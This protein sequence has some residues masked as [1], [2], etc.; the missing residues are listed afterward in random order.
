MASA[1]AALR[2]LNPHVLVAPYN[3]FVSEVNAE[4]LVSEY[5]III[6]GTDNYDARVLMAASCVRFSRPYIYGSVYQFEGQVGVFTNSGPG[7]PCYGCYQPLRPSS[8]V[9]PDCA[10]AGVLGVLPGVIGSTQA[11]EAIKLVLGIRSGL[12]NR[13]AH[14]D[15]TE[16]NLHRF[17]VERREACRFCGTLSP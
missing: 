17:S 1:K 14:F 3:S 4:K 13:V 7:D 2:A 12:Q 15:G 11:L 10:S 9:S 6:D 16:F 5:D 8:A